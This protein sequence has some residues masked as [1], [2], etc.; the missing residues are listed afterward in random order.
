MLFY[1]N[2]IKEEFRGTTW[3]KMGNQHDIPATLLTQ[4]DIPA[5]QFHWSKNLFNPYVADF[6]YFTNE[7]GSG[8]IRPDGYFSFDKNSRGYYFMEPSEKRQDTL[9]LEGK[10]YLQEVFKEYLED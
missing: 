1:G 8:W 5:K 9:V 10:A 4:L 6:A 2:V 3:S 7:D